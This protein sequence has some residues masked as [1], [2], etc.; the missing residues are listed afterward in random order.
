MG[1]RLGARLIDILV[2]SPLMG[3]AGASEDDGRLIEVLTTLAVFVGWGIYEVALLKR[4]G[5]TLGKMAMRIRVVRVADGGRP[6]YADAAKRW[7]SFFG[8]SAVIP[9]FGWLLVCLSPTYDKSGREQGWHD[10]IAH[11]VVIAV[12][13]K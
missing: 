7:G 2:F 10:R 6:T 3:V 8:L 9:C 4:Y 1:H 11:T 13:R 5:A 12:R